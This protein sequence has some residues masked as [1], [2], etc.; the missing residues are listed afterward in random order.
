MSSLLI[1]CCLALALGVIVVRRRSLA[2]FLVSVQSLLLASVGI[3]RLGESGAAVPVVALL[4]RVILIA[5]VLGVAIARTR[6]VRPVPSGTEPLVRLLIALFAVLVV[7]SLVP[8]LGL[9]DDYAQQA[10]FA[11]VALGIVTALSRRATVMQI[12]G[13]V[14]AENGAT[15]LSLAASHG[16][17]ALI[18]LGA[19]FDLLLIAVVAIAFHQR[20]FEEFGSGD[21]AQLRE[22]HD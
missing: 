6:E 11:L 3:S 5:V 8:T 18:E 15:L 16:V 14:V 4:I 10:A 12:I 19:V 21:V 2:L 22:L 20:I 13:I 7:G 1:T 9:G 17:P